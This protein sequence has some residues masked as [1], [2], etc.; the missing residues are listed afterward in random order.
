MS[1][2]AALH[3]PRLDTT[4]AHSA[5]LWNYMLGGKDHFSV[6]RSAGDKLSAL[7]PEL[8]Q[9]AQ[10]SR[11]FLGRA[12]RL[13][14]TK[15]AISQFLDI[16]TGLPSAA[17]THE[18]AQ[19]IVPESRVVYVDNDPMVLVH[20]R[21]LLT[22]TTQGRAD[23]LE[24]DLRDVGTIL[25]LAG[26]TL[27]LTRPIGAILVDVLNFVTDDEEA[28]GVVKRLIDGLPSGSNLVIAHP[29]RQ[30]NAVGVDLAIDSW[31]SH[32]CAP[33]CARSPAAIGRFF[34]GLELLD[35]GVVSCSRWRSDDAQ[36]T[37]VIDFCGVGRKP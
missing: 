20:A 19:A 33:M 9:S 34:D 3:T 25:Q 12:V 4:V 37:E 36:A 28:Y 1:D 8:A 2:F 22:S 18:I 24:A 35:P 29:T 15:V 27:D 6:D 26:N 31:N 21:A 30:V 17:N 7:L 10:A 32:G 5:R 11:A 13:L 23:Y 16:G 14:A